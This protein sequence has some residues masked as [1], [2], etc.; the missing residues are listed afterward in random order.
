MNL[1]AHL[2]FWPIPL[3]PP[4]RACAAAR[5]CTPPA[6]ASC[7]GTRWVRLPGACESI[8]RISEALSQPSQSACT[9]NSPSLSL[10]QWRMR[11]SLF[12]TIPLGPCLWGHMFACGPQIPRHPRNEGFFYCSRRNEGCRFR[13]GSVMT[14]DFPRLYEGPFRQEAVVP[15]LRHPA[16][17]PCTQPPPPLLLVLYTVPALCPCTCNRY[18]P[19]EL[20]LHVQLAMDMVGPDTFRVS[21]A[22]L[23]RT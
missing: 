5:A 1:Q 17:R 13:Y 2:A 12:G 22:S 11:A 16:R 19:P 14:L 8:C 7:A 3:M 10:A 6:G 4:L 18:W 23:P 21:G 20:V 15:A 9:C